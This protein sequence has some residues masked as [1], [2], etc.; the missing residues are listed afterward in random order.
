MANKEPSTVGG[1]TLAKEVYDFIKANSETMKKDGANREAEKNEEQGNK[2]IANAIA[3]AIEKVFGGPMT[4]TLAPSP[5]P[6]AAVMVPLTVGP[7]GGPLLTG[8]IDISQTVSK[9]KFS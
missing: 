7:T 5:V 8:A 6:P 2:D 9:Y 4:I 1:K 3:F